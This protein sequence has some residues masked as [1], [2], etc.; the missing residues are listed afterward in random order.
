MSLTR[1]E[2]LAAAAAAR[3][4]PKGTEGGLWHYGSIYSSPLHKE[5]APRTLRDI[6]EG[7]VP[8][9]LG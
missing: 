6:L 8:V 3:R 4:W 1:K 7:I 2:R 9:K 5:N